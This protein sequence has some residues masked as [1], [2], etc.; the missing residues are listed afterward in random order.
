MKKKGEGSIVAGG[1]RGITK[2][3]A[4]DAG[5]GEVSGVAD[6]SGG[7]LVLL[8]GKVRSSSSATVSMP[9]KRA[10]VP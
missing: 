8:A 4:M 6:W 5:S 1:S 10:V 9:C 7:G 2:G 3:E